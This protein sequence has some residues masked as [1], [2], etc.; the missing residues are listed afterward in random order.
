MKPFY[1]LFPMREKVSLM[2]PFFALYSLSDD[3]FI[4][5]VFQLIFIFN[6]YIKHF[7][8]YFT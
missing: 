4:Y 8:T 2:T 7:K 6:Y 3:V 1:G 5:F